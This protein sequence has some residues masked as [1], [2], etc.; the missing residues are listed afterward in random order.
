MKYN[1]NQIVLLLVGIVLISVLVYSILQTNHV[2]TFE[3]FDPFPTGEPVLIISRFSEKLDWIREAP[4]AQFFNVIYN[5]GPNEDYETN[6]NTLKTVRAENL[7][8]C[9]G[10]YVRFIVDHYDNLPDVMVFLPGSSNME[11]KHWKMAKLLSTVRENGNKSVFMGYAPV[12]PHDVNHEL[13]NFQ[14]DEWTATN[15]VNKQTNSESKLTPAKIRPFG[16]WVEHYL[17]PVMIDHG[18]S[19]LFGMFAVSKDDVWKRPKEFYQDL[20]EQLEV[21]SNPEVGHYCERSWCN[22]FN[23]VGA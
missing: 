2:F 8:R 4:A 19:G 1:I 7:G 12:S 14:L 18:N 5:K 10:T 6:E 23:Y 15:E 11:H 21:S 16:K 13:Y 3:P 20:L 9:D 17:G 22:I